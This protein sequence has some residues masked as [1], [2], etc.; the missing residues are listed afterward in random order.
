MKNMAK[1]EF[2][3]RRNATKWRFFALT[4]LLSKE[5][6]S[7]KGYDAS[8]EYLY[9]ACAFWLSSGL[10]FPTYIRL[11]WLSDKMC[12]YDNS[13]CRIYAEKNEITVTAILTC[14]IHINGK[15]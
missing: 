8:R 11:H 1:K 15:I 10:P 9:F 13:K 7:Y 5:G 2:K 3:L 4:S 12:S 14:N 6:S